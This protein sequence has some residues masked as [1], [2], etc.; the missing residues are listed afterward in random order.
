MVRAIN[1]S[2][3][4]T[5]ARKFFIMF[6]I[7]LT[8]L[9]SNKSLNSLSYS[10]VLF[11]IPSWVYTY[12]NFRWSK[13]YQSF[14]MTFMISRDATKI[15]V[16]FLW[17]YCLHSEFSYYDKFRNRN[18]L[19]KKTHTSFEFTDVLTLSPSIFKFT[20]LSN[21]FIAFFSGV[22]QPHQQ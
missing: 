9:A 4:F 6:G 8:S 19:A 13:I 5:T 17:K 14:H 16:P 3:S 1:E 15:F 21:L 22:F 12:H 7:H 11:F 2:A 20:S 10:A 18:G